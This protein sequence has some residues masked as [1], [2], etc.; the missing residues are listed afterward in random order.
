[1]KCPK[2]KTI[3]LSKEELNSPFSCRNCGG[4][5]LADTAALDFSCSLAEIPTRHP[6]TGT[7][8]AKPDSVLRA[9][10]S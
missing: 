8:T 10:A 3:E 9:M 1:M 4:I 2:C 5:W 7:L 6:R